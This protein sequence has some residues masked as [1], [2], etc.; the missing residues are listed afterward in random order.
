[1]AKLQILKQ[2]TEPPPTSTI[3][4]KDES[5]SNSLTKDLPSQPPTIQQL[6][7]QHQKM[8]QQHKRQSENNN[9]NNN[10]NSNNNNNSNNKMNST[11]RNHDSAERSSSSG[12]HSKGG[13]QI[14]QAKLRDLATSNSAVGNASDDFIVGES[15][16][17]CKHSGSNDR[18]GG[19]SGNNQKYMDSGKS[20]DSSLS[21]ANYRRIQEGGSLRIGSSHGKNKYNPES[22]YNRMLQESSSAHNIPDRHLVPSKSNSSDIASNSN[23]SPS[24]SNSTPLMKKRGQ[25]ES[26]S[27]QTPGKSKSKQHQSFDYPGPSMSITRSGS[28]MSPVNSGPVNRIQQRKGSFDGFGSDDSMHEKYFKS[29]ENTP[30]TRRRHTTSNKPGGLK[31]SDSSPQSPLSPQHHQQQQQHDSTKRNQQKS[32][33]PSHLGLESLTKKSSHNKYDP[34]MVNMDIAVKHDRYA[35]KLK[36]ERS[37]GLKLSPTGQHHSANNLRTIQQINQMLK[38][39]NTMKSPSSHSQESS[40]NSLSKSSK[41]TSSLRH[42]SKEHTLD[43]KIPHGG[44]SGGSTSRNRKKMYADDVEYGDNGNTS[45]LYTNWDQ[46]VHE[47]LLPLQHYI[48]EQAKMSGYRGGSNDHYDSDS[49]RSESPSEHSLSGNEPDVEDSDHSD[50]RDYLAHNPYEDYGA[51]HKGPSYY[52]YDNYK[53]NMSREDM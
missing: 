13:F 9:N 28:F 40:K 10:V 23:K 35:D 37:S 4:S 26:N 33:R 53:R 42:N 46:D 3:T 12:S 30:V 29:V 2:T 17:F 5:S 6:Q 34:D 44:T 27:Q 39:S 1:M 48:L 38:P 8:S 51:F 52:N 11:R 18:R 49:I 45:P 15:Y 36:V 21:S 31:S 22:S 7:A 47:H 32:I 19:G 16:K 24:H 41:N 25:Y 50:G 43:R 14:Q 20:S